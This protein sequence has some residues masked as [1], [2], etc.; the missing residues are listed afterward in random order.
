MSALRSR[1]L[2]SAYRKTF[3]RIVQRTGHH[4]L[5]GLALYNMHKRYG[6]TCSSNVGMRYVRLDTAGT[7]SVPAACDAAE[8]R[9][10]R[11]REP[12]TTILLFC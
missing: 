6:M 2:S 9:T 4:K 8:A 5:K 10:T 11:R 7:Y 1:K 3:D 12:T